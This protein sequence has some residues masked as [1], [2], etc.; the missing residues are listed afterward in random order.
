M[1][2]FVKILFTV[3]LTSQFIGLTFINADYSVTVGTV[4]T[5]DVI[6]SEWEYISGLSASEGTGFRFQDTAFSCDEQISVTID[7]VAIGFIEFTVDVDSESAVFTVTPLL[8][9]VIVLLL[10]YPFLFAEGGENFIQTDAYLG[11]KLQGL[12]FIEP[13]TA[14]DFFSQLTD[15]TFV[16]S[17]YMNDEHF[18][19]Y[20]VGGEFDTDNNIAV[21]TWTLDARYEKTTDDTD[22]AGAYSFTL[23]YD[24]TTG[25][26]KRY[27]FDFHYEGIFGYSTV[28]FEHH[29]EISL[30]G[31]T[32]QAGTPGL[33][34]II[35]LHGL[36]AVV[37]FY[38][39][40]SKRKSKG[41]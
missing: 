24:Q 6:E 25:E 9:L 31:Y 4:N 22:Y 33:S 30:P 23:E 38:T 34:W 16:A 10:D 2:K 20:N 11:I 32:Q 35:P 27:R 12:Y 14:N 39:S 15:D 28:D 40:I 19:Y 41:N 5:Y 18:T 13:D 8:L 36:A 37:L 29:Q 3:I 7:G 26:L 17:E 21:F 1:E